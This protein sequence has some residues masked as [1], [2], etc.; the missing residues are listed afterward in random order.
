MIPRALQDGS[1]PLGIH[2]LDLQQRLD[3][4]LGHLLGGLEPVLE[5]IFRRYVPDPRNRDQ[6]STRPT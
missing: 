5:E 1:G 4:G 2:P 6:R 3:L